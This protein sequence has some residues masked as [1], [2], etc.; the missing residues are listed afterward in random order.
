MTTIIVRR[1]FQWQMFAA[2]LLAGN[3]EDQVVAKDL[4][5]KT[6]AA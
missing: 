4:A 1:G 2:T 5:E 3:V 6:T